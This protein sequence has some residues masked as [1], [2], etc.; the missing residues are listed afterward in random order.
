MRT[1][2]GVTAHNSASTDS[3]RGWVL[4][5]GAAVFAVAVVAYLIVV[6]SHSADT[7]LNGFDL[8][9]YLE[10]GKL[11][12]W[13]PDT[14]YTW[15][16]YKE[17]GIMFT[18]TPFAAMVFAV[19]SF[20]PW[21]VLEDVAA[22][23]STLALLTTV[24]IAFRELG[25]GGRRAERLGWTLLV[26]GAAFW[27]E[28]V[29]RALHLGQV[30]LLLMVLIV[31][32]MCQPDRR[33]F[34]GAGVGIAAAIKLVPLLFIAYLLITRRF[35]A[36]VVA[37]AVFVA[38]IVAGFVALPHA[39]SQ[40]WL[41]GD[42]WQAG[43]TGFVASGTNQS[44][45]GMITRFAGS[46]SAGEPVWLV[47]AVVV[48]LAGLGAAYLLHQAGYRFEGLM[49]CA[50][51]ALLISP[52]SW[53]HHWI[54]AAP[55]LAV[56]VSC[57]LRASSGL[58]RAGWCGAA[59]A[60]VVLF[61]GWPRFWNAGQG[62]G[63]TTY[64]PVTGFPHGDNPTYA[65]YHWHG[66]QLLEGNLYVLLGCLLFLV[67][68]ASAWLVS[69]RR[70]QDDVRSKRLPRPR[71]QVLSGNCWLVA[72]QICLKCSRNQRSSYG[73]QGRRRQWFGDSHTYCACSRI[74][75]H[76]AMAA[77]SPLAPP[78]TLVPWVST[79]VVARESMTTGQPGLLAV[80]RFAE[81]SSETWS[82]TTHA[83]GG[84]RFSKAAAPA[85]VVSG[86]TS[87]ICRTVAPARQTAMA[88]TTTCRTWSWTRPSSPPRATPATMASHGPGNAG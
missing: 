47:A 81:M 54:W 56:M 78:W 26:A 82:E 53:D 73:G 52:I 71:T 2:A 58:A 10:G 5:V 16:A 34:K 83:P 86:V 6:A 31:W 32:D 37:S 13:K 1:D 41:H 29:Q 46:A 79:S 14:L 39:S 20:L 15:H 44:L 69:S 72:G 33:W 84:I 87:A 30:E 80:N 27:I 18:Y 66:I 74:V 55:F 64:A 7:M 68:L 49:T 45:R 11:A 75:R 22:V 9:V 40:W 62:F 85:G 38:T 70:A 67:A 63:L 77:W 65:E 36:A 21:R 57:V 88:P 76:W 35:R 50:L 60:T 12:R 4:P 61:A 8:Q 51:T 28:P 42:F 19:L 43:R 23:A 59:V 3:R 24:W 17:P 25:M 48:G